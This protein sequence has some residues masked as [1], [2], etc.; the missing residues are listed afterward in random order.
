MRTVIA[1][2]TALLLAS[3]CLAARAHERHTALTHEESP[4]VADPLTASDPEAP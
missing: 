3:L 2:L 4:P 1:L